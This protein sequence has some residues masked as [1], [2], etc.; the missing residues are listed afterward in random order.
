MLISYLPAVM[1]C[2]YYVDASYVDAMYVLC[3]CYMDAQIHPTTSPPP[4]LPQGGIVKGP[5]MLEMGVLPDVAAATS[6][7]MILLTSAS[8]CMV[9]FTF[10]TLQYDY[11]VV[12]AVCGF[13][14]TLVGQLVVYKIIKLLG[15]RS[16]IVFAM[17]LF[18][19]MSSVVVV[20]QAAKLTLVSARA[21]DLWHWGHICD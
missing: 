10:G 16:I 5:L 21:H 6:A 8:A 1:L 9:Y 15:R 18:M 19:G 7:T 13:L 17:A 4:S 11:A 20:W 12:L 3:V 14:T 2:V